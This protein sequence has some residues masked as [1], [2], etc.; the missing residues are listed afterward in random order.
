MANA[1][2][3]VFASV[4]ASATKGD[5]LRGNVEKALKENLRVPSPNITLQRAVYKGTQALF[6]QLRAHDPDQSAA[7]GA[8]VVQGLKAHLCRPDA[9]SEA[10]RLLRADAIGAVAGYSPSLVAEMRSEVL[11]MID[12]ERSRSV[13][14]RLANAIGA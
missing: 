1:I 2:E 9:G 3:A 12:E 8:Q 13:R 4:N 10:V 7:A 14:D 6:E 5:A 11:V